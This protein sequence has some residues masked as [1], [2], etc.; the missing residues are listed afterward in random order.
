MVA[1]DPHEPHRVATSLELLYDL[2]F[3]VAIAEASAALHHGLA[4][5]HGAHAVLAFAVTFFAIWWAWMGF[6]WF[7]SAFDV[8]DAP[9]R[10][11][12]LVQMVGVLV[13]AAGVPRLF[14]HFDGTWGTCGYAIMRVGLVGQ[15]L[16]AA[17]AVPAHRRG[18]LRYAVGIVGLQALWLA[19]LWLPRESWLL[20]FAALA[21]LELLVPAWAER[22]CRTPWHAHHIAERYGLL[23]IIVLGE[24]VLS[25]TVAIEKALDAGTRWVDVLPVLAAAPVIVFATWWIYFARPHHE[26]LCTL[27]RT[28]LWGYGHYLIFAAGAGIGAGIAV[29]ADHAAGAAAAPAATAGLALAVPVAVFLLAYWLLVLL[30][31]ERRRRLG[32]TFV[33]AM[34]VVLASAW[35]PG[36]PLVVAAVLAAVA[37]IVHRREP[38]PEG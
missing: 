21:P 20:A 16:R 14:E 35:L 36:S 38:L 13:L 33:V 3:V 25:A 19:A 23:T 31:C 9:Y 1:R 34:A 12:V 27:R 37:V 8:D 18:A 17:Y 24:S 5:G 29:L 22:A 6:C 30:P 28:F 7:A 26:L 2:C 4:G 15:W 11:L 10:L 32:V